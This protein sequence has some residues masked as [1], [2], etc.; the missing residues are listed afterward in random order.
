MRETLKNARLKKKK[1][2]REVAEAIGISIVGYRQ[3][4][5]GKRIGSVKTWDKR[6]DYFKI[7]QRKLRE[8]F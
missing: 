4:E 6:E 8:I 5:H 7:N 3:I 1:T 2:Q